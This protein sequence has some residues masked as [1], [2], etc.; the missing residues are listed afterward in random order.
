MDKLNIAVLT[1]SDTR[2]YENDFSGKFLVDSLIKT[3]H[4]LYV[5]D[6]VEDNLYKIRAI[7]AKWIADENIQAIITTGG[8]GFMN[9]DSTPEAVECL[10]DQKIEGFG[11]F[12]RQLSF[13]E[14]G[15]STIQSRA[16]AGLSNKT[17]ICC[18]PG[19]V[20]ACRTAWD[21]ILVQQLDS[22]HKPCNFVT[23]LKK[24]NSNG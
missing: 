16:L 4:N 18:L 21:K 23:N 3:G 17:F 20:N 1:I 11:E 12:F 19:S 22:S 6:L 13:S 10:L 14:V 24:V 15:S 7:V 9:R 2:H 5:R 8:T